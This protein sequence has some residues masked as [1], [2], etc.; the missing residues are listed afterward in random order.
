MLVVD[1][2][3][4]GF[5]NVDE[6]ESVNDY[7]DICATIP[8]ILEIVA[9]EADAISSRGLELFN[10]EPIDDYEG[11]DQIQPLET[12]G[13]HIYLEQNDLFH[14]TARTNQHKGK[15]GGILGS[16]YVV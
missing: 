16:L 3:G 12:D 9:E 14:D 8:L 6:Y 11:N 7:N 15:I 5:W 10:A 2:C 4:T 13:N 1:E